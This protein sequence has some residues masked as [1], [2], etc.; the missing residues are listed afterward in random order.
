MRLLHI[1]EDSARRSTLAEILNNLIAWPEIKPEEMEISGNPLDNIE[2]TFEG[3][4]LWS[5]RAIHNAKVIDLYPTVVGDQLHPGQT[6]ETHESNYGPI[7]GVT[8]RFGGSRV[9]VPFD[10]WSLP[11]G[12]I[13]GRVEFV[14]DRS[15]DKKWGPTV[16][17]GVE[18]AAMISSP[19]VGV[20]YR[21]WVQ[22]SAPRRNY[23]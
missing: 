11:P 9:A 23:E 8:G 4:E 10:G 6:F 2:D 1:H 19:L 21:E 22:I 5:S 12:I 18:R 20:G 14:A 16:Q 17:M 3:D 7:R 15:G 13:L